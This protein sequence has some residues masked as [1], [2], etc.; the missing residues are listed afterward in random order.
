MIGKITKRVGAKD[1]VDYDLN[2][3]KGAK[4]IGH[5][6]V[7]ISSRSS[8]AECID[9]NHTMN[10][11]VRSNVGHIALSFAPEDTPMLTDSLMREVAEIYMVLMG[12]INT[13]YIIT[14][15]FDKEHQHLHI[16]YSRIDNDARAIPNDFDYKRNEKVCKRLTAQYGF[17]FADGKRE[18]NLNRLSKDDR[19]KH[20]IFF[21]LER[22]LEDCRSWTEL[23]ERLESQGVGMEVKRNPRTGEPMGVSFRKG[24]LKFKGSAIDRSMSYSKI[25][26]KLEQNGKASML[27]RKRGPRPN[28]PSRHPTPSILGKTDYVPT[29]SPTTNKHPIFHL[30]PSGGHTPGDESPNKGSNRKRWEDMTE[31]ER[32]AASRGLTI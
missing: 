23:R 30:S 19:A 16:A 9:L 13:P 10:K 6:F 26:K 4:I 18:I 31:E 12:I 17:H 29:P 2:E 32:R 15:H 24:K 8:I 1:V 3:K 22:L 27:H 20:E 14:R 5:A 25:S 21:L 11:R 28:T 7:D